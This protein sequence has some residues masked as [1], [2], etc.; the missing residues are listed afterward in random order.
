VDA[1]QRDWGASGLAHLTGAALGPPDFSRAGV[2][3]AARATAEQLGPRLGVTVDAA[4]LLAG[5]AALLGLSRQGRISAGG[6][7]RL[8]A[9]EDGWCALTLSRQDDVDAVPAL[10]ES[11]DRQQNSWPVV[12]AWAAGRGAVEVVGRARLLGLPA[13]VLGEASAAAPA[14][15]R[16]GPMTVPRGPSGLLV[17]DLSSM[18]AGPLCGQLLRRA[19]ATVVKVETA[20][21]PDGTRL[22]AQPFFDWMNAGKLCYEADFVDVRRLRAL[23]E[24][25]DVVLESSRPSALRLRGLGAEDVP[26]RDGRVWVRITGHGSVGEQANWTAFGDDAAVAG[27]LVGRSADGPVFAGDAIAD[28][29]TGMHAALAVAESLSRGGGEIVD[30]V[31]ANVAAKYAAVPEFADEGDCPAA[32]PRAPEVPLAAHALG[33]DD[34]EVER[35]VADRRLTPC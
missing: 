18:W 14:V 20:S 27:G 3:A 1:A 23:L 19:G 33:A 8:I 10:V 34:E 21:R 13:S 16:T 24:S 4:E 17:V 7:T 29:L 22:G 6:A 2:L 28:P 35:L 25:A 12:E 11:I 9:A 26:A 15:R 5:R 31:M 32:V 30:V